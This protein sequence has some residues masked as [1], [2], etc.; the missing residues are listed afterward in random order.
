[1]T[2]TRVVMG[3]VLGAFCAALASYWL[4]T[5]RKRWVKYDYTGFSPDAPERPLDADGISVELHCHT[6]ASSDGVMTPDQL[7]YYYASNGFDA[8]AVTD[9]NTVSNV[10]AVRDSARAMSPH[11]TIISGIEW[12]TARFH[13]NVYG[14][15]DRDWEVAPSCIR[16]A[17][18]S[19]Y[20]SDSQLRDV[21][22][23]ADSFGGVMQYNH[24]RD[25]SCVGLTS[26]EIL[27]AGF[28]AIEVVGMKDDLRESSTLTKFCREN[29]IAMT[30]GSDTHAPELCRLVSNWIRVR[31]STETDI[32]SELKNGGGNVRVEIIPGELH[33]VPGISN[34]IA[35]AVGDAF[36]TA[37]EVLLYPIKWPYK[38][39]FPIRGPVGYR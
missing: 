30:G 22:L 18:T 8:V 13:A 39:L 4:R 16:E 5:N 37:T 2:K 11:M 26:S 12:T 25:P 35:A 14:F 27:S 7:V 20:P 3:L 15:S 31:S 34:G 6:D 17:K 9:H 19:D 1:M 23:W 36:T 32:L 28:D 10:K 33:L 38:R 24:P 29:R 21:R